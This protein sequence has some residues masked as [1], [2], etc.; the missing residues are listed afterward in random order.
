[1]NIVDIKENLRD[2]SRGRHYY[3]LHFH[4]PLKKFNEWDLHNWLECLTANANVA[5]VLGSIP[6]QSGIWATVDSTDFP[7]Q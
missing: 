6:Q 7:D 4:P 3:L 2:Q 5:T 1:M